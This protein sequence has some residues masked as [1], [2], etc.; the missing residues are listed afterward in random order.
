[1]NAVVSKT[2]ATREEYDTSVR[3]AERMQIG[4][5]PGRFSFV[6]VSD[7]QQGKH[8]DSRKFVRS[9]AMLNYRQREK[10]EAIKQYR[11]DHIDH[12]VAKSIPLLPLIAADT[13]QLEPNEEDWAFRT[14]SHW[15]QELEEA[16][17]EVWSLGQLSKQPQDD[18]DAL[19]G[20]DAAKYA[21][22]VRPALFPSPRNAFGGNLNDLCEAYPIGGSR[23][24]YSF[25]LH[26]CKLTS[27]SQS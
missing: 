1:M 27:T 21:Y 8:E 6:N 17:S 2:L 7:P 26:H 19:D 24:Y 13:E 23:R 10:Q 14:Y 4:P 9:N 12:T 5:Q 20:V 3:R 16:L 11:Q 15:P 18:Y 22:T 25:F